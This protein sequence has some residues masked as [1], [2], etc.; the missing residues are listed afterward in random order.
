MKKSLVMILL[1]GALGFF[2]AYGLFRSSPKEPIAPLTEKSQPEA[3]APVANPRVIM[4]VAKTNFVEVAKKLSPE[5]ILGR[6]KLMKLA[7]DQPRT[8][9]LLGHEFENLIA[10]GP[11]AV[12]VIG[13]FLA[14]NMDLDYDMATFLKSARGGK[15][16]T[17]FNTP[18]SLRLGLF[19]TLKDIGG[20]DAEKTLAA[21]LASTGSGLEVAFLARTLEQLSPGKYRAVAL[22]AAHDLLTHPIANAAD[23]DDR[24]FLFATLTFLNDPSFATQA[25]TQLIQPDGKVDAAALKYLQQTQ[26]EKTLALAL[27]A[28]QDPRV[29]DAGAKERLAQVA[30]DTAG[31]DPKADQFFYAV[32]GDTSLPADN[33]RNLA[34]DLADHG[35]NPKNPSAQDIQVMLKRLSLLQQLQGE[36]TEPLVI[37]G[38]MEAQKDLNKFIAA[39]VAQHPQQ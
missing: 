6:L 16:P 20:A 18:P 8:A 12:P 25:Q 7:A 32:M 38:I 34:E 37:A 10:C 29:T 1:G 23:K 3:A 27:K 33:R 15:L 2:C 4:L 26:P 31:T 14:G 17:E 5:E 36:A 35:T 19:E 21:A 28:Y 39:Y 11:A 22:Q 9:R 13:D 30:L 24:N